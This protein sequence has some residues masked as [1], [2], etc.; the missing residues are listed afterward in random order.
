MTINGKIKLSEELKEGLEQEGGN[1]TNNLSRKVHKEND[2][3]FIII[4]KKKHFIN[5]NNIIKI[6]KSLFIKINDNLI[7]LH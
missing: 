4:N 3:F 5:N 1:K 7:K 6:K 2:K